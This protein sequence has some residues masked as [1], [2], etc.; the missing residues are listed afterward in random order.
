MDKIKIK[1][2]EI[3]AN[4]GLFKEEKVLGQKFLVTVEA[5][6]SFRDAAI[7][8][9]LDKSIDYGKLSH[10]IYEFFKE[11]EDLLETLAYKL[12][13]FIFDK[14]EI[15]ESLDVEIKKP[16]APINLPLDTAS[17]R[18]IK[19]RRDYYIGIGTNMGD[20]LSYIDRAI[21]E[22]E[23]EGLKILDKAEII[24]TKAWGKT[25][26]ADFLNTVVKVRSFEDPIDLLHILQK[27][28]IDLDRVRHEKWGPRTIDLDIL[29]ID[30]EIIYT[31]EL[32][33]PHP[34]LHER[35]FVLESLNELIPNYFHPILNRK[36]SELYAEVQ[37][38]A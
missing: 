22:M 35:E 37:N 10:E 4:H 5:G 17:V 31:D 15:V 6:L 20:R 38:E 12:T 2:L 9:N 11:E 7:Y 32:I 33:V 23:E 1:D 14:Y 28:E 25:D 30:R 3:Y 16:W 26:Q 27:I 13:K 18:C 21:K 29:L 24:E 19:K 8:K 34:Y 36:I